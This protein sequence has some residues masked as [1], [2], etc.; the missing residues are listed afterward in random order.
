MNIA[1][2][3]RLI[4]SGGLSNRLETLPNLDPGSSLYEYRALILL[5][6]LSVKLFDRAERLPDGIFLHC[7]I[8]PNLALSILQEVLETVEQAF[9]LKIAIRIEDGNLIHLHFT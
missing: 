4:H 1:E 2:I 6:G 7:K 9:G 8:G 5:L 3:A